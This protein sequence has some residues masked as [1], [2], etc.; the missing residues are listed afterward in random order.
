MDGF[1]ASF[2]SDM[3]GFC[4]PIIFAAMGGILSE[5]AGVLNFA[6]EGM[7]LIGAFIGTLTSYYTGSPWL[8]VLMALLL[9][10]IFAMLHAL[11]SIKFKINQI[12][13]SVGINI[14]AWGTAV[15]LL[16][17]FFQRMDM[18]ASEKMLSDWYI[19]NTRLSFS[20]LWLIGFLIV[21]IMWVF[22]FKTNLGLSLRSIGENPLIM[23]IAGVNIYKVRYIAV[24]L[25]G[26]LA[27]IAGVYISL[28]NGEILSPYMIS[29]KGFLAVIAVILGR[30]HPFGAIIV[31]VFLSFTG[32]LA[33]YW[34]GAGLSIASSIVLI[35]PYVLILFVLSG[36]AGKLSSPEV[37]ELYY[38]RR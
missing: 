35:L 31:A 15:F 25:S 27:G 28:V 3:L 32:V 8:G 20:P 24:I 5:R 34:S 38:I 1:V 2:I 29:G 21:I 30:W 33:S 26:A 4:F 19:I 9:G 7:M 18:S 6:L 36:K 37:I 16:K 23:H 12:L 13:S 14:L 10:S 17:I 11:F 22:L